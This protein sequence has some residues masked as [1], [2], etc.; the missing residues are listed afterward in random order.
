[1]SDAV[2]FGTVTV[3]ASNRSASTVIGAGHWI[4][5]GVVS[6]TV[7][8]VWQLFVLPDSSVAVKVR[9]VVPSGYVAVPAGPVTVTGPPMSEAVAPATFTVASPFPVA[10]AVIGAGH[11]IEGGVV[12]TTVTLVWHVLWSPVV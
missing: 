5:G 7:T 1:M 11:V 10:S 4:V 6:T 2:A 9:V 12:S 8:L 3:A